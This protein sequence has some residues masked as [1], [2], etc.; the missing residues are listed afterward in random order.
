[1]TEPA[2][3]TTGIPLFLSSSQPVMCKNIAIP[4][5]E[6]Q[7]SRIVSKC[8]SIDRKNGSDKDPSVVLCNKSKHSRVSLR[9]TVKENQ[10]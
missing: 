3:L 8:C 10:M 6:T 4:Y 1:M 7:S 2:K 9:Q 5:L